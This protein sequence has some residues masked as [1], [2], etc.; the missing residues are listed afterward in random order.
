MKTPSTN[1]SNTSSPI[2]PVVGD[3]NDMEE[4]FYNQNYEKTVGRKKNKYE[5]CPLVDLIY[6]FVQLVIYF[7]TTENLNEYLSN[8]KHL[9]SMKPHS[10]FGELR[11]EWSKELME[12]FIE[13]KDRNDVYEHFI[14]LLD[15]RCK[16]HIE[17]KKRMRLEIIDKLRVIKSLGHYKNLYET[18]KLI[19]GEHGNFELYDQNVFQLER[20][21]MELK[22]NLTENEYIRKINEYSGLGASDEMHHGL[23][24][25]DLDSLLGSISKYET[26][27]FYEK[28]YG[29]KN[30][31]IEKVKCVRDNSVEDSLIK[32]VF[33]DTFYSYYRDAFFFIQNNT[34]LFSSKYSK[35][36]SLNNYNE[37]TSFHLF[38]HPHLRFLFAE[39]MAVFV[40]RGENNK[41]YSDLNNKKN[42]KNIITH[43]F[44]SIEHQKNGKKLSTMV[45]ESLD[46]KEFNY[47]NPNESPLH[48]DYNNYLQ[49]IKK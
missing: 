49:Q 23:T 4:F 12:A 34:E 22:N 42:V 15:A 41:S 37:L 14:G 18:Y 21:T 32:Y 16:D 39:L 1:N 35:T 40:D 36:K 5:G 24:M 27:Y 30:I 31:E 45:M 19:A 9:G 20:Q 47:F 10:T 8:N 46:G 6:E 29:N 44:A 38:D 17:N 25:V 13:V 11:E 28:L 43:G 48:F 2:E 3:E 26:N 7:Y 33:S